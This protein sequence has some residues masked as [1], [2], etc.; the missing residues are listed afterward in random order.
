[1]GY[2]GR[3]TVNHF[4]CIHDVDINMG[5]FSKSFASIGGFISGSKEVIDY[6]KH[7]SRP[8]I[9][10]ASMPPSAVPV[11]GAIIRTSYMATHNKKELTKVLEVFSKVKKLFSIPTACQKIEAVL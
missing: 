11:G 8:F 3:G 1:M 4:G 2:Q 7:T 6:I 5:T 9:F 10:S